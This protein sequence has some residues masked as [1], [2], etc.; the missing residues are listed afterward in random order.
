M[1]KFTALVDYFFKKY[2]DLKLPVLHVQ[3]H[4]FA[5][6]S[7]AFPTEYVA[8][9]EAFFTAWDIAYNQ[10]YYDSA[11]VASEEYARN[12][13]E[14]VIATHAAG[15]NQGFADGSEVGFDTGIDQELHASI[16]PSDAYD[17]E[18]FA[19]KPSQDF[20]SGKQAFIGYKFL[21]G[22]SQEQFKFVQVQFAAPN[23][24]I[25]SKINEKNNCDFQQAIGQKVS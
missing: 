13:H 22:D 14:V 6:T 15:Y 17:I 16:I 25:K 9:I 19:V 20:E 3:G 7:V 8:E 11:K 5:Q 18:V 1:D 24:Q 2:P 4:D 10:G 21:D 23:L 12:I